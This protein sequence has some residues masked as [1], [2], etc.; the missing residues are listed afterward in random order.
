M[1][2]SNAAGCVAEPCLLTSRTGTA[3]TTSGSPRPNVVFHTYSVTAPR[4]QSFCHILSHLP[5]PSPYARRVVSNSPA[6]AGP[7]HKV[8][9]DM[10]PLAAGYTVPGQFVQVRTVTYWGCGWGVAMWVYEDTAANSPLW[11]HGYFIVLC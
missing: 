10:G 1:K 2:S 4:F 8:V 5:R 7:L 3:R 9:I 6:A 11:C